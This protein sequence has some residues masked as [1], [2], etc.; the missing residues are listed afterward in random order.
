MLKRQKHTGFALAGARELDSLADHT[1]RASLIGYVLA[2]LEGA[3]PDKVQ[4][5]DENWIKPLDLE[6][7]V[8]QFIRDQDSKSE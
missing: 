6:R 5:E 8:L 1:V 3:N 7:E 2:E 4:A